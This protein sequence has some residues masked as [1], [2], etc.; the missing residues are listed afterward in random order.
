MAGES[1][2]LNH[3]FTIPLP[4]DTMAK[5]SKFLGLCRVNNLIDQNTDAPF[6]KRD[7]RE[8]TYEH[9]PKHIKD[10]PAAHEW[11]DD[12]MKSWDTLIDAVPDDIIHAANQ[13]CHPTTPNQY[14]AFTPD[15]RPPFYALTELDPARSD[16]IRYH[17]QRI[18]TFGTPH[19]TGTY[20]N[21]WDQKKKSVLYQDRVPGHAA[22]PTI[23][24]Y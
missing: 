2:D 21:N 13:P 9:A 17:R 18:D 14:V 8:F 6:T 7:M 1:F 10:T 11:S 12:I 4:A 16:N 15:N 19:D 20:V 24:R 22:R 23:T 3:R 5:W